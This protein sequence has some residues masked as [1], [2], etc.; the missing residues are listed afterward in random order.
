VKLHENF[1]VE[2]TGKIPRG[3]S[4]EIPERSHMKN[5]KTDSQEKIQHAESAAI[6]HLQ[7]LDPA[8]Q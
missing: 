1:Q 2:V 6:T 7:T 5:S 8:R 3:K 4:Q